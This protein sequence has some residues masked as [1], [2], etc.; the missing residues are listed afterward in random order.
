MVSRDELKR[1]SAFTTIAFKGG[2]VLGP[3]I[4]GVLLAVQ[5]YVL[6]Y[7][8]AQFCLLLGSLS[9]LFIKYSHQKPEKI[10]NPAILSEML[11][12]AIYVSKHPLL[13]SVMSLDMFAVLFG[14][15]VAM[16]PIY[17]VEVLHMGPE[18]LGWLR[19][20]PAFGAVF[21]SLY[22][23]RKPIA[24]TR[25]LFAAMVS[26]WFWSLHSGFRSLH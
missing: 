17:A 18:G 6:P 26:F 24:K 9:L 12:G 8:V 16:L 7:R 22:L 4:A 11:M 10:K 13:L 15:V 21:M 1:S 3:G 2:T 5:G 23:I 14:G 20:A 25:R 19:A